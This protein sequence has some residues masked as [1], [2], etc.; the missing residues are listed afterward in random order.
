MVSSQLNIWKTEP[1][2]KPPLERF[3]LV[4]F[5]VKKILLTSV[6]PFESYDVTDR[7]NNN[8]VLLGRYTFCK[9]KWKHDLHCSDERET[10][11]Y[12]NLLPKLLQINSHENIF[13]HIH[14][15]SGG[16]IGLPGL[17]PISRRITSQTFTAAGS[18]LT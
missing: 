5:H 12:T 8:F 4:S 13:C 15:K 14:R 6:D 10:S 16:V 3:S 11:V 18:S 1:I 9:L 7:Q 2:K 17:Y